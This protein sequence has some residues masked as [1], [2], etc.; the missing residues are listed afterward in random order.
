MAPIPNK[1]RAR[2]T[3][4][5]EIRVQELMDAAARL[6][7]GGTYESVTMASVAEAAGIAKPSAYGYFRSKETLFMA[8]TERE[9]T[10]WR[11]ALGEALRRSRGRSPARIVAASLSATLAERPLLVHLLSVVHATLQANLQP[12]EIR[13]FKRFTLDLLFQA[14]S[15]IAVRVPEIPVAQGTRLLLLT[16]ALVIGL[17][18]LANAPRAVRDVVEGDPEFA[19][20]AI[21][22]RTELETTLER[23]IRG[24]TPAEASP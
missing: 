11:A 1:Q 15:T 17:G 9:L 10:G 2:T 20:F 24:W 19:A 22:F 7:A 13:A 14:A 3:E 6:L 16:Y 8:L 23:L 4:D 18:Q 12:D 21:D 5:R